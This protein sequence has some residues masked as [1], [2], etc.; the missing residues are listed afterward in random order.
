[1]PR[2]SL[3]AWLNEIG[4]AQY[5]DLLEKNA[6]DLDVLPELSEQDLTDLGIPL[7]HRKRLRKA[8]RESLASHSVPT[9]SPANENS[10][11]R[12]EQTVTSASERRQLTV[13]P[14]VNYPN[15]HPYDSLKR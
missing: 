10:D 12:E 14:S 3:N 9:A 5:A 6:V 8:L 1:M 4:L 13:I 11:E 15:S 2:Q 7:G